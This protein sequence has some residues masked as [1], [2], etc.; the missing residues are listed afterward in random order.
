MVR[1]SNA[2]GRNYGERLT[3]DGGFEFE[4]GFG[5]GDGLHSQ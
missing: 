1:I 3:A 5:F 4:D 2:T